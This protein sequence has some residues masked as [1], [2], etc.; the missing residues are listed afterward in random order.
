MDE[1]GEQRILQGKKKATSVRMVTTMKAKC[2]HRKGC[3]LFAVHISCDKGKEAKDA[4]VL[5]KYLVLEEFHDV[6]STEILE[7]P[8]NREV[9]VSIEL[10]PG[11]TPTSKAPYM[12]STLELVDLKLHLKEILDKGYIRPSLSS[13]GAQVLFLKN[14]HDT[15]RLCINYGKLNKVTIKNINY[16]PRIDDLF[17]QLK[18]ATVLLKINMRFGCHQ[19]HNK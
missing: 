15:L 14:K 1:N 12:M 8:P 2:N 10:V 17:N 13:W 5:S 16:F 9:D 11:A 4:D 6:L 3:V 18:G 19:V 7:F